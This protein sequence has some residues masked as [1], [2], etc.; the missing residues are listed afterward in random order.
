MGRERE[1]ERQA[2]K[3]RTGFSPIRCHEDRTKDEMLL[4]LPL[5]TISHSRGS[6][7]GMTVRGEAGGE[8]KCYGHLVGGDR[9][10]PTTENGCSPKCQQC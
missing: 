8:E 10:A 7:L 6:Q 1:R 9:M 3:K 5:L 4:L 2:G